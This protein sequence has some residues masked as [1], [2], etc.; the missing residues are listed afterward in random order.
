[1]IR[2]LIPGLGILRTIWSVEVPVTQVE[3]SG[4][5]GMLAMNMSGRELKAWGSEVP[6]VMLTGAQ[7]LVGVRVGNCKEEGG[8]GTYMYISRLPTLLN[9]VQAKV[10]GPFLRLLLCQ[11]LASC[12]GRGYEQGRERDQ[13]LAGA[14]DAVVIATLGGVCATFAVG[15]GRSEVVALVSEVGGTAADDGVDCLE[16][17][18]RVPAALGGIVVGDAELAGAT[19]VLRAACELHHGSPSCL[20]RLGL[21]VLIQALAR[22]GELVAV[23]RVDL[24]IGLDVVVVGA[25][26]GHDHVA[27]AATCRQRE[28]D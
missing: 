2:P 17:G 9:Q 3:T 12:E 1:M 10:A 19:A 27:R 16:P 28:P 8:R 5:S 22:K 26:K 23:E 25:R 20:D 15:C 4:E 7:F 21:F 24:D 11:W 6:P 14:V 13:E 18:R